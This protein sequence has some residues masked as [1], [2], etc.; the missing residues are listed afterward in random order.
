M[1]RKNFNAFAW[2]VA[3]LF[4]LTAAV[5]LWLAWPRRPA[6]HAA[7]PAPAAPAQPGTHWFLMIKM[8][9]I[10]A[11]RESGVET[12]KLR[13]DQWLAG[14]RQAGFHPMRFSEARRRIEEYRGLPR[15]TA[16]V[17]FNPG[18]RRTYEIVSP[19]FFKHQ[20]PAVWL[21]NETALKRAD[22]RYQTYHALRRM[23]AGGWDV[24]FADSPAGFRLN[25]NYPAAAWHPAGGARALNRWPAQRPLEFLT[26]NADWT[27]QELVRRLEAETPPAGEVM[28]SRGLVQGREWGIL[29][30][31]TSSHEPGFD[32]QTRPARRGEKLFWLGTAGINDF[33]LRARV[34]FMIGRLCLQLRFDEESGNALQLIFNRRELIVE[35]R[36]QN[37]SERVMVIPQSRSFQ[38]RPF[39][40]EA[41]LTGR[42]M[43]LS[44]DGRQPIVVDNL[45]APVPGKGIVQLYLSDGIRGAAK[46]DSVIMTLK[47]LSDAEAAASNLAKLS[48]SIP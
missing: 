32:L 30:P 41:V 10:T 6:A 26:V 12:M 17:L 11:Q 45:A 2:N 33:R 48:P 39:T 40:V 35:Q 7:A 8:P 37:A 34:R 16:V 25:G 3:G 15:K 13:V 14:L 24:G 20:F 29:S 21:T 36:R 19:I 43:T 44:I 28:L 27:A 42:R 4:C 46:A 22:R 23:Q 31:K 38:R 18:Y 1:R 5:F 47:P 9:E